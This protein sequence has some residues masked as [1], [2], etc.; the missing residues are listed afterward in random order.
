MCAVVCNP[1][2]HSLVRLLSLVSFTLILVTYAVSDASLF[3]FL[4]LAP[5]AYIPVCA[6][7][8]SA[9]AALLLC[10]DV[11]LGFFSPFWSFLPHGFTSVV[12]PLCLLLTFILCLF[13]GI[14][15]LF[16]SFCSS[17]VPWFLIFHPHSCVRDGVWGPSWVCPDVDLL[18]S[19]VAFWCH[20]L[21]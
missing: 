7:C 6:Q 21:E 14:F 19:F 9:R 4:F 8:L 11:S 17:L 20:Q 1:S 3:Y 5:P 18:Q 15:T 10:L 16:G 13:S 12:F 2:D